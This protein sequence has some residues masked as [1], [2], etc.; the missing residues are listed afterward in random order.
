MVRLRLNKGMVDGE[1]IISSDW[2]DK[3][4]TTTYLAGKEFRNMRYGY[5]WWIIQ[6]EKKIYAAIGNSGNVIYID[7][8][9]SLVISVTSYF[10]PTIYDRIDFIEGVL[11]P[12]IL[13]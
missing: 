6:D 7:H 12:N 1:Q 13:E 3:I 5:L 2:I 4:S 8:D 9:N 11:K 10:K